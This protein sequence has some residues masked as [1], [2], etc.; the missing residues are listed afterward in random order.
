VHRYYF[1]V[2]ALDVPS[3]GVGPDAMPGAVSTMAVFH[4]LARAV[5]VATYQ[6]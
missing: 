5:L 6:R 3:L 4:T 1:A 2:H